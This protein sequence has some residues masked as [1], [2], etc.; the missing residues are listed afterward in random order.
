MDEE[1]GNIVLDAWPGRAVS[2]REG[3]GRTSQKARRGEEGGEEEGR[4]KKIPR[5][6]IEHEILE[7]HRPRCT[8]TL[9]G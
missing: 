6:W 2:G 4:G 5:G 7:R 8:C 9:R 3:G 1:R